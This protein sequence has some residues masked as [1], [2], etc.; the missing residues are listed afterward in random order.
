MISGK[1]ITISIVKINLPLQVLKKALATVPP[2]PA[3]TG[4]IEK[5]MMII[6][7]TTNHSFLLKFID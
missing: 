1:K 7:S 3:Y 6:V 2:G 4:S 5:Q